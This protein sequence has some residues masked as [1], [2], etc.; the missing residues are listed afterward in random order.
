MYRKGD[1]VVHP[2]HGAAV[3]ALTIEDTNALGDVLAQPVGIIRPKLSWKRS[4]NG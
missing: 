1:T 4:V 2:E 3:I